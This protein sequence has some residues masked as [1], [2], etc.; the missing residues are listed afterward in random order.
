MTYHKKSEA[1]WNWVAAFN[2]ITGKAGVYSWKNMEKHR[3]IL[4]CVKWQWHRFEIWHNTKFMVTNFQGNIST[5]TL[6]KMAF[7]IN[8]FPKSSPNSIFLRA[9][10]D[11]SLR[12]IWVNTG[13]LWLVYSCIKTESTILSLY[14]K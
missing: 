3:G 14:G 2:I 9:T 4:Y 10:P 13:F 11:E 12:K 8:T 5:V 6:L 7:L 1:K